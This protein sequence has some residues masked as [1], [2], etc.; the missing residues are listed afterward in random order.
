MACRVTRLMIAS[1]PSAI[2]RAG[3]VR[4]WT[5]PAKPVPPPVTGNQPSCTPNSET[6]AMAA[7]KEGT[8]AARVVPPTTAESTQPR[9]TAASTPAPTP[10]RT[11]STVA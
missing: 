5:V 11:N 2:E 7:T 4:W 6:S 8:E 1:A 9:R 3:R 10:S